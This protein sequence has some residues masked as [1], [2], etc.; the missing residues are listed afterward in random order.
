MEATWQHMLE[1]AAHELVAAE[2]A[3]TLTA[4]LALLVLDADRSVVEA[5]DPG[6]GKSDAKDVAGK[7]VEHRLLASAPGGDVEDPARA[8]RRV[9]DVEIRASLVE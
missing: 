3:G 9:R 6:V 1:K 5:D 7:V 8:P 4:G 2:A